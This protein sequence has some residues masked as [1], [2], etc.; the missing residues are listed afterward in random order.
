M[1][2]ISPEQLIRNVEREIRAEHASGFPSDHDWEVAAAHLLLAHDEWNLAQLHY[3][4][5]DHSKY[6]L[7]W[8]MRWAKESLSRPYS[9]CP[10][11]VDTAILDAAW[12]A[13]RRAS[14]FVELFG[15]FRLYDRKVLRVRS[16][17]ANR[18]VFEPNEQWMSFDV[19]DRRVNELR[20]DGYQHGQLGLAIRDFVRAHHDAANAKLIDGSARE[21]HREMRSLTPAVR[22]HN[23]RMYEYPRA[24]ALRP[25]VTIFRLRRF[26]D[27]LTLIAFVQLGMRAV[28]ASSHY[29]GFGALLCARRC[30]WIGAISRIADLSQSEIEPL[31][32]MHVYDRGHLRPDIALTPFVALGNDMLATGYWLVGSSQLERN[33]M[34]FAA[35]QFSN[36]YDEASGVLA[37][38]LADELTQDFERAGF[39]ASAKGINVTTAV[40]STDLDLVV[41]SPQERMV[42]TAELKWLISTADVMEVLNRGER[43]CVDALQKQLP[44]H[45][46]ARETDS[47]EIVRRAFDLSRAPPIDQSASILIARG[48]VGSPRLPIGEF[49]FVCDRLAQERLRTTSGQLN[50][51]V[52][53]VQSM[54]YLPKLGVHYQV[55]EAELQTESGTVLVVPRGVF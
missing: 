13:L 39:R 48:Y 40:G 8:A 11:I 29:P 36:E 33:F 47:G 46:A 52:T 51:F 19:L 10:Q 34:A 45:K 37:P 3:D 28:S 50:E 21:L 14:A 16:A 49:G 41:W 24:W 23:S 25:E 30:E 31:L 2:T 20:R 55:E 53:W 9:F 12:S 15:A 42:L 54:N 4:V 27:A 7:M 26:W 32:D 38:H 44:I 17:S 18:I 6:C 22:E 1:R 5:A 35:S 43:K